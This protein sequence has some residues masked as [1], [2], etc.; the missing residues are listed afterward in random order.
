MERHD[1]SIGRKYAS[2]PA[3]LPFYQL[4]LVGFCR[5]KMVLALG[6]AGNSLRPS[7]KGGA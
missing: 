4:R 5:S 2:E 3:C 6:K 1:A 7:K